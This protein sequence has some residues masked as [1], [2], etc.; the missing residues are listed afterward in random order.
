MTS[1]LSSDG[2]AK[3]RHQDRLHRALSSGSRGDEEGSHHV[4]DCGEGRQGVKDESFSG[5]H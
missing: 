4:R 3:V 2:P 5:S 1:V